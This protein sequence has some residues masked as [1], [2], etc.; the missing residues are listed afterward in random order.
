MSGTD[1]TNPEIQQDISVD[2]L[3]KKV[4]D[5]TNELNQLKNWLNVYSIEEQD[6]RLT[7]IEDSIL[8]CTQDLQQLETETLSNSDKQELNKLKTKI[9]TLKS[10][11]EQLKQQIERQTRAEIETLSQEVAQSQSQEGS[12]QPE[13]KEKW[14]LWRQRDLLTSKEEW[15]ENTWKNILRV[16]WWV[17]ISAWTVALFKKI[18]GK[19]DKEWAEWNKKESRQERRKRRKEER[20]KRRQERPWWKRFLIWAWIATW[21]VVWWVQVYKHWNKISSWFKEKLWL[22]LNFEEARQKVENEVRNWKIDDEHFGAF[23]AN[24]DNGITF[25]EDTYELCSYDQKTKIDKK[26]KKIEWLD[27]EFP[28]YE[29]LIHAA[30]IVNFAKRKLRWRWASSTPFDRTEWWWDI[31]FNCSAKWKQEFMGANDSNERARILGTLSTVWWGILWWYCAWVKWAAI[32][33]LSWWLWWYALW[34]YI[35]NSSAAWRCC[36]TI[37]KWNN[38][39]LF[40]N[41]LNRQT[42][43][44]WKSLWEAAWEQHVDPNDTPINPIVDNWKE[45]SEWAWILAEIENTYWED[46]TWRRNLEIKW[47]WKEPGGNPEEYKIKSY[48]HELKLTIKWWPSGNWEQIDYS[49]ITKIHIEKYKDSDWWDW[50]DIDFPKTEEWLKEAIKIANLTNM[51]REDRA[52]KWVE[53][54][55]FYYTSNWGYRLTEDLKINRWRSWSNPTW[56]TSILLG[57][58]CKDKFPTLFKD[59]KNFSQIWSLWTGTSQ[60]DFHNQ[61]KNDKSEWSQ[62]IKFL[63]QMRSNNWWQFW[64]KV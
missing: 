45:W 51:I 35:D 12:E 37:A 32:W 7:E 62:Y 52:W 59:L 33:W 46:Q 43:E 41:Y 61:A 44:N 29:E 31:C 27:V 55:P 22:A 56:A 38:L 24:F 18:F 53:E 57:K 48:G 60:E 2:N 19:K 28:S 34:S 36:G 4:E 39:Q 16:V 23:N 11:K 50:L 25:N 21:T 20:Q 54:Y 58:T 26:N 63:N 49:K 9:N 13:W 30:N 64:K 15:K 1:A 5:A 8:D 42:D 14:F 6:R 47:W 10:S 40:I 3:S 17:W